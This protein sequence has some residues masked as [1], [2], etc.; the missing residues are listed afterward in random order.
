MQPCRQ[1]GAY[2]WHMLRQAD[3]HNQS[4]RQEGKQP[5]RQ[6]DKRDMNIR[7]TDKHRDKHS[8]IIY[9][10]NYTTVQNICKMKFELL[11]TLTEPTHTTCR[12][13]YIINKKVY[14]AYNY[15]EFTDIYLKDTAITTKNS[16]LCHK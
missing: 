12:D 15:L 1:K 11:L 14:L 4:G 2:R 5:V 10:S 16:T 13:T 6:E 3:T 9:H 7:E 8:F